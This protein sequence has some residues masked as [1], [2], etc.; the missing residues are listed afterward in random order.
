M[1]RGPARSEDLLPNGGLINLPRITLA[2]NAPGTLNL[3]TY[4]SYGEAAVLIC[5]GSGVF[6]IDTVNPSPDQS[7]SVPWPA[8]TPFYFPA[9]GLRLVYFKQ[10]STEAGTVTLSP[11]LLPRCSQ[12]RDGT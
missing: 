8:N 6:H 9:N 4:A 10:A 11:M 2:S 3:A 12:S 5:V 7:N 1:I